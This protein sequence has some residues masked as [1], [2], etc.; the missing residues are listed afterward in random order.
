MLLCC[1]VCGGGGC[2]GRGLGPDEEDD[3]CRHV[4]AVDETKLSL[5]RVSG[6]ESEKSLLL[7]I[8]GSW[9]LA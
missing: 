4:T 8:C 2:A 1:L 3:R 6:S 9:G 5:S 7:V